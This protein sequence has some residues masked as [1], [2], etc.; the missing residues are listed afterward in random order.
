MP[1]RDWFSDKEDRTVRLT[2][3]EEDRILAFR[4]DMHEY[5]ELSHE[6]TRTSAN[7]R[8]FLASIPNLEILEL[9]R[10]TTGVVARLRGS[11]PG[12]EIGLRADIDAIR[13]TEETGLPWSSR[14]PGVMHACGHDFHTASLLG[15][16][17]ILSRHV[18]KIHGTVDF[19]FQQAEEST[20]GMQQ[21]LDEGL[22]EA[23]HPAMFF[24]MHN[25][26]EVETGKIVVKRGGL[27]ASKTNFEVTLTG[28]GG[29]GAMPHLCVDPIVCAAAVISSLQTIVSRNTDPLESVVLTMGSIHGGSLENLVVDTV[30]M[31]GS[32]RSLNEQAR[33]YAVKRME[34]IVNLTAQ[35]YQCKAQIRYTVQI[36]P[37]FNT[38]EMS[39]IAHRAATEVVGEEK[40]V[41]AVPTMA[42]EDFA[43]MMAK[44]P[45]FFYWVGS[46]TPGE[47][48][49]AWHQSRFRADDAGIAVGASLYAQTVFAAYESF[50]GKQ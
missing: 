31:T 16:A 12:P 13:Q 15:A 38:D 39:Q 49:Y 47:K 41:D 40:V 48:V 1:G 4:H 25:R 36:P 6:E 37:I 32:I 35:A 46:G 44:I 34:S 28:H 10:G 24:G 17:L 21:M 2:A 26:P 33:D 42:S 45:S 8:S 43:V 27:M 5:P 20:D 14:V 22:L 30:T 3:Q 50:E 19:L 29:H 11:M 18:S 9:P 23:I 7:I